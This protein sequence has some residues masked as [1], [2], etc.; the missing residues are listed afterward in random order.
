MALQVYRH[1]ISRWAK[2][3]AGSTCKHVC[4]ME[5]TACCWCEGDKEW[6]CLDHAIVQIL[7]VVASRQV[8]TL[9]TDVRKGF[10][11]I[12]LSIEWADLKTSPKGS[13]GSCLTVA[14]SIGQKGNR[15][16]SLCMVRGAVV[17]ILLRSVW[18]CRGDSN[19]HYDDSSDPMQSFLFC[20]KATVAWLRVKLWL[21]QNRDCGVWFDQR[22]KHLSL[23]AWIGD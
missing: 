5:I 19:K 20:I 9:S 18:I 12:V 22:S 14:A 3:V 13:K 1:I 11:A 10:D 2:F 23:L 7:V 15:L 8:R 4:R 16:K 17:A 21:R 6:S